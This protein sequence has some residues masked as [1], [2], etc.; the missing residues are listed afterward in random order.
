MKPA[1]PIALCQVAPPA[2]LELWV[3]GSSFMDTLEGLL[4]RKQPNSLDLK[5]VLP[6]VWWQ[7][8]TDEMC[9]E[10]APPLGLYTDTV[11]DRGVYKNYIS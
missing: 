8:A 3:G 11:I 2:L 1:H 5:A 4:S 7:G 9:S 10:G 6:T